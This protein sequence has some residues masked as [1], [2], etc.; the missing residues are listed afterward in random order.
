MTDLNTSEFDEAIREHIQLRVEDLEP[1]TIYILED[2]ID[3]NIWGELR[4]GQRK[5]AG[6]LMSNLVQ[7][8]RLPMDHVGRSAENAKQYQLK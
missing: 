7:N 8:Q 3:E 6:H 4:S 5:H 2:I 1:N